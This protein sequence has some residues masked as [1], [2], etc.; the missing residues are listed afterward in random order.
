MIN[1]NIL[2]VV[3]P[4]SIHCGGSTWKTFWEEK[5]TVEEKLTLGDF[6]AVNM[7]NYGRR[8]VKK[9]RK[10][11]DSD[12][13]TAWDLPLKFDNLDNMKIT[14][15]EPK[16]NLEI[17]GKGLIT[18]LGLKAKA[19]TKKYKKSRYAI[20]NVSKHYIPN[21]IRGFEKLSYESYE[22]NRPNHDPT[23]SNFYLARQLVKCM[24]IADALNYHVYPLRM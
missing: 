7:K 10:L 2:A 22:R 13:Y 15:S 8:N 21:I 20:E 4:P 24:I 18:S 14:S 1:M 9:H 17:S 6:S 12:K 3:T 11:N 19:R 16:D 5:F 23:D